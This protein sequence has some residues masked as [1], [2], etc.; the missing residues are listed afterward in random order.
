MKAFIEFGG[1]THTMLPH[2]LKDGWHGVIIEPHPLSL[3]ALYENLI[4]LENISFDIYNSLVGPNEG[5]LLIYKSGSPTFS[6]S[7]HDAEVGGSRSST[8]DAGSWEHH[9]GPGLTMAC[10][11]LDRLVRECPYPVE[12]FQVD[13]E[14]MEIDIFENYS[15]IKKPETIKV[16]WHGNVRDRLCAVICSQGYEQIE[17]SHDEDLHFIRII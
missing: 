12:W 14:G 15:W 10:I 11:T 2:L 13:C 3:V 4:S 9:K 8:W 6:Q 1:H 17:D 5:E 16:A 7:G